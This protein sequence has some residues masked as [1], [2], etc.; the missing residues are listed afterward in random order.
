MRF[1]GGG[2]LCGLSKVQPQMTG[3]ITDLLT[4]YA[5]VQVAHTGCGYAE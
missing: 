5:D 4:F 1:N 2:V 3:P